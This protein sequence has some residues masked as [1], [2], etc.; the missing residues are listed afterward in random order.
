MEGIGQYLHACYPRREQVTLLRCVDAL[1]GHVV[2]DAVLAVLTVADTGRTELYLAHR[3]PASF[4]IV[5]G[6]LVDVAPLPGVELAVFRPELP[7]QLGATA[8][9]F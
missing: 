3:F 5:A 7:A 9:S 4:G 6:G 1:E 8:M 2:A